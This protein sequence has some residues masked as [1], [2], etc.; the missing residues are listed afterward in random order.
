MEVL[1]T[2]IRDCITRWNATAVPFVWSYIVG[3]IMAEGALPYA[4]FRKLVD[5][6][7]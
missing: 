6:H 7:A 2:Q 4:S 3:E 5:N 1:I